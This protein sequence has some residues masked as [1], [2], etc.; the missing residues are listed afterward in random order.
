MVPA[1]PSSGSHPFIPASPSAGGHPFI[2]GLPNP[3]TQI[4]KDIRN[5]LYGTGSFGASNVHVGSIQQN[6]ARALSVSNEFSNKPA[7]E[8][9]LEAQKNLNLAASAKDAATRAVALANAKQAL[10]AANNQM[11]S[12][13]YGKSIGS[14]SPRPNIP[15]YL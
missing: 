2:S 14:V 3:Q 4:S 5:S 15:K 12:Q 1:S 9:L 8:S 7:Q 11:A 13:G 10:I 6:I